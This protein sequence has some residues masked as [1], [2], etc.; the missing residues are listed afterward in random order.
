M[1]LLF[2]AHPSLLCSD[3]EPDM[4]QLVQT[5]SLMLSSALSLPFLESL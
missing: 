1:W 2:E 5:P 3:L 4:L